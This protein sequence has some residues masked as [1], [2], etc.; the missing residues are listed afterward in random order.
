MLP[1]PK[2]DYGRWTP[3]A[4]LAEYRRQYEG[5]IDTLIVRAK[6][7][8]NLDERNDILSLFLR[9][10]YEDGSKM[11]RSEI[12]DE[13]LALL[14]AGHETTASTLGWV[15]ERITPPHHPESACC[16]GGFG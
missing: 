5:L 10:T 13:L 8:P 11:T 2:R 12:G 9:S 3:W 7:D 15:F 14:A 6:A 4:R 1:S 16:R